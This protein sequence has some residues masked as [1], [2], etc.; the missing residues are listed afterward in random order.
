[1]GEGKTGGRAQTSAHDEPSW[2]EQDCGGST[3]AVGE[4]EGKAIE[5][6]GVEPYRAVQKNREQEATPALFFCSYF[7][8]AWV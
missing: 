5:E 3:G 7:P 2:K 4:V 1:V 6:G 8:K